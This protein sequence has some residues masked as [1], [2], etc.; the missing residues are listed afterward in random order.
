MEKASFEYKCFVQ[1]QIEYDRCHFIAWC[2]NLCELNEKLHEEISLNHDLYENY[3]RYFSG[4]YFVVLWE[5]ISNG[6]KYLERQ[7]DINEIHLV[8]I[9]GLI[10]ELLCNI[11][12]DDYFMINYY[13]N[14]ASHIFLTKYSVLNGKDKSKAEDTRSPFCNK[15][16]EKYPLTHKDIIDKVT[17]VFGSR[18]GVKEEPKYKKKLISRL[19][20]IIHQYN[21]KRT[22]IDDFINEMQRSCSN[23]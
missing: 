9:R 1:T 16:G 17:K 21:L 22:Q 15:N 2:Y 5:I 13:R 3:S 12:D 23:A 11:S 10:D 19:Y 8:S 14:C 4:S 20:P 7:G 18:D 6:K